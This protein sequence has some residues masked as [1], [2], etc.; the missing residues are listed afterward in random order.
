MVRLFLYGTLLDPALLR[1]VAGRAVPLTPAT[2]KGWRRVLLQGTRYPTIRRARGSVGG[3]LAIVDRAALARLSAYEGPRYRLTR[4]VVC[5]AR[6]NQAAFAWIA[7]GGTLRPWDLEWPIV[8]CADR[9]R[10]A[11]RRQGNSPQSP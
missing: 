2:L 7:P 1:K 6:G 11:A 3:G 5:T 8:R 9:T 4:V 10:A